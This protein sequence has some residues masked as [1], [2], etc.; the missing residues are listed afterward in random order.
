MIVFK[1]ALFLK[2]K[3]ASIVTLILKTDDTPDP[4]IYGTSSATDSF[5]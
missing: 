1:D 2:I 3:V 5:S 4:L